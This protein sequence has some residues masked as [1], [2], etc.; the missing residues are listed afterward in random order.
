MSLSDVRPVQASPVTVLVQPGYASSGDDHWQTHWE[1]AYGYHRIEQNDWLMPER[2]DWVWAIEREVEACPTA[3]VFAAHSLGCI[4]IAHWAAVSKLTT[5]VRGALFVA[6]A[7]VDSD[8]HTPEEVRNFA[9]IPERPLPFRTTVI[10]SRDDPFMD[11]ARLRELTEHWGARFVD[12]GVLGHINSDS[13]LSLW[14]D[15]HREL[16]T[17]MA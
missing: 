7:D 8:E 5:K 14:P 2:A 10:A 9:P 11:F 17:L 3:V 1:K 13:R 16:L 15:G 6:P 4:A 12:F